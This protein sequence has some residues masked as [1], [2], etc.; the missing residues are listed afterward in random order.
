M[1]NVEADAGH[2]KGLFEQLHGVLSAKQFADDLDAAAHGHF[3]H[4]GP[5]FI[6]Y[7][8]E[9]RERC[10]EHIKDIRQA[11]ETVTLTRHSDGQVQRVATRFALIAAAGELASDAGITGW[12]SNDALDAAVICF[13]S[14]K[15]NW[16]PAGSREAEQALDRVRG[17]IQKHAARFVDSDNKIPLNRA[18]FANSIEHWIF[19]SVFKNE[20]CDGMRLNTVTDALLAAGFL[21]SDH[22]GKRQVRRSAEGQRQR[23]YVIKNTILGGAGH[24]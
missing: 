4:A 3:G 22:E 14:W 13:E 15:N 18:G 23:F 1:I 16:S 19:P 17:F 7:I 2:G 5:A 11:F 9:N 24:E 21:E 6:K 12:A 10:V 20:I 8:V